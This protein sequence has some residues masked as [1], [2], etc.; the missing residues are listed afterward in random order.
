[1]LWADDDLRR[2]F[3]AGAS[4]MYLQTVGAT[5]WTTERE[6]A[7]AEAER[8]YPGGATFHVGGDAQTMILAAMRAMVYNIKHGEGSDWKD[9]MRYDLLLKRLVAMFN[10]PAR[11][12]SPCEGSGSGWCDCAADGEE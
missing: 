5:M 9:Y 11:G 4:W 8:R 1:M 10:D 2:V 3:V 7:E 6:E 12:G